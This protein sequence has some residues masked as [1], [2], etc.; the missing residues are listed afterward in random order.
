MLRR[1]S[2]VE[3]DAVASSMMRRSKRLFNITSLAIGGLL[4]PAHAL[5][6]VVQL[7]DASYQVVYGP[8]DVADKP[9]SYTGPFGTARP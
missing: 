8:T 3:I 1:L 6:T 2:F 4:V 7:P 5:A 9:G